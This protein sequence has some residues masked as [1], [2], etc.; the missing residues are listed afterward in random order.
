MRLDIVVLPGDGIGP[1]VTREAVKVLGVVAAEFG[2]ELWTE[3]HLIGG[4][5]LD[6]EGPPLPEATLERALRSGAVLLG[7]VGGPAYDANPRGSKPE[8][9]LLALRRELGGFANLRPV[10][11]YK[12][13]AAASPLKP[14]L[15]A[16]CDMLIVRELLGGLYYG[17]PR[18]IESGHDGAVRAYNTMAYS[19]A[20]IERIARV[21]FKAAEGRRRRVTSVDKANVLEA[22]QLWRKVVARVGQDYPE[23][24]LEH[25]LVD[26][27]AMRLITNPSHFD[28]VLAENMFGDILS[29]EAAV[30]AGSIGMLASATVG[31][32]VNLYEPVHGSAPDIAGQGKA[33]PVG[34]IASAAL[35]L[36]HSFGLETEARAVERAIREVISKGLR[37]ADIAG[38]TNPV[39][40]AEMGDAICRAIMGRQSAAGR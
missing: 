40:T 26:S 4:R 38:D 35:M 20:E 11:V 29:D 33:N 25:M 23:V 39:S 15:I 24:E 34:A 1:E 10:V 28:V 6:E 7:A 21:A 9:G 32:R 36:R 31:G 8:D 30:I 27:C 2:H 37:T 17:R 16:Q 5:A 13:L 22:S 14:E 3:D 18:G 12:E 19:E